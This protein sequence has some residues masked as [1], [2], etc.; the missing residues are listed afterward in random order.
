MSTL[1]NSLPITS[2]CRTVCDMMGVPCGNSPAPANGAVKV[3][4]EKAFSGRKADRALL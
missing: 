3:M 4:C 1:F 2:C